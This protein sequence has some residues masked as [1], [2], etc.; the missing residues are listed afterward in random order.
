MKVSLRPSIAFPRFHR[1]RPESLRRVLE[2]NTVF[3]FSTKERIESF[4]KEDWRAKKQRRSPTIA[5]TRAVGA[6]L[7]RAPLV[8][9]YRSENER[10][11][12]NTRAGP[13]RTCCLDRPDIRGTNHPSFEA[14]EQEL[15]SDE[16]LGGPQWTFSKARPRD[17]PLGSPRQT[18]LE[19]A[20]TVLSP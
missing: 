12:D 4:Q 10:G 2:W 7:V 1:L 5:T 15:E 3:Q 11:P 17:L 6:R 18:L 8:D 13:A 20:L 19:P 16:D 14:R 9:G